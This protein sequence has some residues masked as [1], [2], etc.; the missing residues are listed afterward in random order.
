MQHFKHETSVVRG[1][2]SLWLLM[3]M[4]QSI[5]LDVQTLTL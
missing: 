2:W 1:Y 3:Y 4:Q 5:V